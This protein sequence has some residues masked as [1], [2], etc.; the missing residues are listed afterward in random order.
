MG[1]SETIIRNSSWKKNFIS[2]WL[3]LLDEIDREFLQSQVLQLLFW[4]YYIDDIFFIW[5]CGEQCSLSFS[6]NFKSF[7]PIWNLHMKPT[8]TC[9]I[10]FLDLNE[11][12]RN[13]SIHTDLYIKSTHGHQCVDHQSS[14]SIHIQ[15]SQHHIVKY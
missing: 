11:S 10:N 2:L 13:G 6:M 5:I 9:N 7:I 4:L 15:S 3:Y 12:F 8:S 14:H 1:K